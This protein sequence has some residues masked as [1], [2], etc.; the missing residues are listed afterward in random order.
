M[1]GSDLAGFV[2]GA[3]IV[4]PNHLA[5]VVHS[6]TLWPPE[7]APPK[8]VK[9]TVVGAEPKALHSR[10]TLVGVESAFYSVLPSDQGSRA[11]YF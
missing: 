8:R 7:Q 3:E 5:S 2:H 1:N 4:E 10:H 9:R 6:S 11:L